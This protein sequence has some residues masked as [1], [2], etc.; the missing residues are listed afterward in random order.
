VRVQLRRQ[1][2]D[3]KTLW[4]LVEADGGLV[5]WWLPSEG[6]LEVLDQGGFESFADALGF[7][8]GVDWVRAQ[9]G[10]LGDLTIADVD[11]ERAE[12]DEDRRGRLPAPSPELPWLEVA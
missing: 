7:G 6:P 8:L 2:I 3:R 5:T 4:R 9:A 1:S 11:R 12:L 10:L